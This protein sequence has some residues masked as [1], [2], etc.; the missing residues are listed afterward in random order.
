MEW[1]QRCVSV[2]GVSWA[3]GGGTVACLCGTNEG[4]GVEGLPNCKKAVD[5]G[6]M[7]PEDGVEGRVVN[8]DTE[9]TCQPK[10]Q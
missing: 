5:V 1:F 8:L 3:D 4:I 2:E 6:V 9:I 7:E 10:T